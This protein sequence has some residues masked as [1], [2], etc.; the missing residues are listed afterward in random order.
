M[1]LKNMT[2]KRAT[3]YLEDVIEHKDIVPF[4]K[5]TG[6][7]GRKAQANKRHG[8]TQGRWPEKSCRVLLDLLKNAQANAE[9]YN[10][11]KSM[12]Q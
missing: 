3:H 1:A 8:H 4:R 9:V 2:V 5:F 12:F 7:I 11:L 6:G 10:H